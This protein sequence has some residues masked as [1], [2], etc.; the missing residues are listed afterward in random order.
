MKMKNFLIV[1]VLAALCGCTTDVVNDGGG[2][3][4]TSEKR[5]V[6]DVKSGGWDV[7]TRALTAD[8]QDMSDL[9]LF[10]YVDG[11]LVSILHKQQG[12]VDFDTPSLSMVYGEHTIYFVASRGKTPT[13]NGTGITWQQP[14]DTFWKVVSLTVGSGTAKSQSVVLDRVATRLRI[15][16]NDAVPTGAAQLVVKPAQWWYGL[17]YTTGAAIEEQQ[18]ERVIAVPA[19]YAG[20]TGQLAVSVFG[21]SDS[22]EWMTDVAVTAKDGDGVVIGGVSLTDVPFVRNRTTVAS[23]NLFA[24]EQSFSVSL[25]AEWSE[26]YNLEW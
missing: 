17:D 6:F 3:D 13:V 19:S 15:V 21:M 25:N 24:A 26:D 14:S 20:T 4:V 7:V 12:D 11:S 5:I 8:G 23:G 22:D 18:T 1:S 16:V 10:D 2:D 9:W